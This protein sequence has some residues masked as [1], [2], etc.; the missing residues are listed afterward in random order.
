MNLSHQ[1]KRIIIRKSAQT[2]R[3][4]LLSQKGERTLFGP[5]RPISELKTLRAL[6]RSPATIAYIEPNTQS[7]V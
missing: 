1:R 3:I 2:R 5:D 4:V 6:K 7:H